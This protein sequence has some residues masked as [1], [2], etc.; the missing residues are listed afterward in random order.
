MGVEH[1]TI[2]R[3]QRSCPVCGKPLPPTTE[4]HPEHPFCCRRCKLVDLGQWLEGSYRIRGSDPSTALGED[5]SEE[6]P[7]G[8]SIH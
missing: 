1:A 8:R 4:P 6:P 2:K 3:V 7:S 5:E